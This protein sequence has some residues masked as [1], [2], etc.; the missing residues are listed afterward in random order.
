MIALLDTSTP[1]CRLSLIKGE[2]RYD[3]EWEAGR[4]LADGLLGFLQAE[5]AKQGVQ[6][7]DLSGMVIFKGPGSFTGLRIGITVA[8]TL[9]YA[10]G[11]PIVGES[12]EDWQRQGLLRLGQGEDDRIVLPEY[13]GEANITAPRK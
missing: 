2:R 11:L 10:E 1:L 13:G 4:Q 6:L 12:G 8:N 5:V 3:T 7:A 9:A